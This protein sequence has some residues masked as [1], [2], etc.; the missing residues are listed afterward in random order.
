MKLKGFVLNVPFLWIDA[1]AL[2]PFVFHKHKSPGPVL[3]NHECIHLKQQLEMGLLLFYIWYFVEYLIRFV[4]YRTH[5]LAYLHISFEQE[6]YQNEGDPDYLIRRKFW[7][8]WK[9]V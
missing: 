6:A 1:I 9:Y 7:A 4:Q 8:F 3:L 2:F 5:Y